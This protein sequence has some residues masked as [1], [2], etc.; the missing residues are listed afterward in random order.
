MLGTEIRKFLTFR[1]FGQM[2]REH[3]RKKQMTRTKH[4]TTKPNKAKGEQIL[5]KKK[6]HNTDSTNT[7]KRNPR[8]R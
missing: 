4:F 1:I 8:Y 7:E 6:K 5:S 3:E 2:A